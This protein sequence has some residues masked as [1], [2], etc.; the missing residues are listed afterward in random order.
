MVASHLVGVISLTLLTA[1]FS[2]GRSM[3]FLRDQ[4]GCPAFKKDEES[5]CHVFSSRIHTD[6]AA[7]AFGSTKGQTLAK[8]SS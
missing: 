7:E 1:G 3:V 8:I 2:M 4:E 5:T 6:L